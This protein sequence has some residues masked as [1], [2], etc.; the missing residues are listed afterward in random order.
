MSESIDLP[1][2]QQNSSV[3]NSRQGLSDSAAVFALIAILLVGAYFRGVGLFTWDGDFHLHPDERFLTMVEAALEWPQS[4]GEY[5]NS[6]V[7]PLNPYNQGYDFFVYGTLPLFL[8]KWISLRVDMADYWHV[9]LVGRALSALFDLGTVLMI[10]AIGARLYSRRVGL[11]ASALLSMTVLHIQHAHFFTVESF[12]VFFTCVSFYAIILVAERGEWYDY[13]LA[14]TATG[15]AITCKISSYTLGLILALAVGLHIWR[16]IQAGNCRGLEERIIVRLLVGGLLGALTIRVFLPYAFGGSSFLNFA[17]SAHW[18]SNMRHVRDLVSGRIDY[19]PSHQWTNRIPLLFPVR[20]MVL[21]GMGLPLGI[22]VWCGWGLALWELVQG[23]EIKHLLPWVWVT[24]T[25]LY[26]GSQFVK[27]MR[28]LLPI[29]PVFVLLGAYFLVRVASYLKLATCHFQLV[30][31]FLLIVVVV[32]TCLWAFAF[33]RIYARPHS[34]VQASRW[35]YENVPRGSV[36]ANEHWDDAL[37]LSFPDKHKQQYYPV[38]EQLTLYDEDTPE[39]LKK[40]LDQLDRIDYI[41]LSSNRLYASIP[42]LPM[43]YPMTTRYYR[44]LFTCARSGA[45]NGKLG[46]DLAADLTSYPTLGPFVFPDQENPFPLMEGQ[47]KSIEIDLPPAE[48]A[49]SVYDHPRVLIFRKTERFSKERAREL[50]GNVDWEDIQRLKPIEA[51]RAKH[52]LLLSSSDR[53]L[54]ARS[55]TWSAMFHPHDLAN[56]LPVIAWLLAVELIG[57][58]VFPLAYHLLPSLADRG[59]WLSK[60]LGLLLLAW[61]S[62]MIA[63]LRISPYSRMEIALSLLGLL[64]LGAVLAWRKWWEIWGFVRGRW[65][66]LLAG[67]GLFLAAFALFLLIRIGNPDLWHPITGGEKPM[68]FAYLNAVIKSPHFPPY[69]P[70]YAGGY[71]NYYYFGQVICATLIKL[72]GIV[73]WVAYNLA[74]PLLYGLAALGAFS[75][76]YHLVLP[77]GRVLSRRAM[78]CGLLGVLFVGAIG[79]LGEVRLLERA[80]CKLSPLNFASTIPGLAMLVN[81]LAGLSRLIFEGQALPVRIEWWYWNATRAIASASG[82]VGPIN[83]FPFFTFLYG[84]LHAHLIALPFALLAVALAVGWMRRWVSGEGRPTYHMTLEGVIRVA[85]VGL[86]V[87][88]LWVTNTWDYPAYMLVTLAALAIGLY[89]SAPRLNRKLLL[90][91]GWRALV[92]IGMSYCAFLPYHLYYLPGYT[93]F[94]RWKGSLTRLDDYLIMHGFFLFVLTTFLLVELLRRGRRD[95]PVY[96]LRL[97]LA[98][99]DRLSRL[100]HLYDTLVREQS[101]WYRLGLWSMVAVLCLSIALG[102]FGLGVF[103]LSLPPVALAVLL[104]LCRPKR[105]AARR[106]LLFAIL[107]AWGLTLGVE[108]VVLKGDIGRMN[109]VFKFYFQTWVL[110]ALAS[111]VALAWTVDW[112]RRWAAGWPWW[113]AAFVLLL[114]GCLIYPP[115]AARAKINDRFDRSIGPTLDGMAYMRTATYQEGEFTLK[116]EW[117]RRAV[118]WMLENVQ[119]SPVVLEANDLLYR[120]GNRVSIYTGL[121]TIV[122]W[123]WH[124]RQQRGHIVGDRV[125]RRVEV[126]GEIYSTLDSERAELLLRRFRVKYIY[127]G[128]LE[129]ALYPTDGLAKFERWAKEGFLQEVY[130]NPG[131]VIYS[132]ES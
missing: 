120:W 126:V 49:F 108:V 8:V 66:L 39:K 9:H 5:F 90:A 23:R 131:V 92:L 53:D 59:Y 125:R 118:R 85:L 84:D 94:G 21:W 81:G 60:S 89:T 51:S 104:L 15:L 54:Y 64:L 82:E 117:D 74:V 46:F 124:Q 65:P 78:G 121:P 2:S 28:Y 43:R 26:Q 76:V 116:L 103:A 50:L 45:G 105:S 14:G 10:F 13:A 33:T 110:W 19:P 58:A 88:A 128:E 36:I 22:A 132:V 38:E 55:G 130:R 62:W 1:A 96:L 107:L 37:P 17:P 69:D 129:R 111:A 87:G 4:I 56:R 57:L 12:T 41:F 27:S 63:S 86:C 16:E 80:L 44:A 79:N 99:W 61:M 100:I 119:G 95:G 3:P 30:T 77:A 67:E 6:A 127:L 18:L 34:R 113:R 75:I 73:P 68:D 32:G 24:L 71:I 25:F 40:L 70:W 109:T 47:R 93:S 11:L 83:E 115:L 114:A 31:R 101:P 112:L 122:G 97:I 48:E 35:I 20:N 42:R 72:T 123:D 7:S 106:F 29:Y 52:G 98:R 91:F 102:F